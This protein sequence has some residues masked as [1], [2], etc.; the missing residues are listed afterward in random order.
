[1]GNFSYLSSEQRDLIRP[2]YDIDVE[3]NDKNFS[4]YISIKSIV[5]RFVDENSEFSVFN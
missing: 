5:K 3:S 4:D 1:M 2:Y